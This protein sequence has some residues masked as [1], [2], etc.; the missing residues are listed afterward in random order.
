MGGNFM[1][2]RNGRRRSGGYGGWGAL[3]NCAG[4]VALL[5]A[6]A[7]PAPAAAAEARILALGDSIT[8][9]Y[10]LLPDEALPVRLEA[11]LRADGFAVTIINSGV[12]GDTTAGGLARLAWA[13]GDKPGYALVAL[14]ANDAL[15]GLDPAE[16][17]ANLDKILARLA[18]AQVKAMLIGMVAPTNW[19]RDYEQKFDAIYPTLAAKWHVPLYPFLLEGVALDPKLNQPDGLHPN[20]AGVA[21]IVARMAPTVERF[22]RDGADAG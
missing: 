9:G 3:V 4:A 8:A 15:R 21:V 5:L 19:G 17:F 12:S 7:C 2:S 16:A 18:A 22:L 1:S 6:L 10:G 14:G 13:L 11:R 20:A